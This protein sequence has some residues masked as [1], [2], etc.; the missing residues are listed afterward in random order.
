[1][2]GQAC[3]GPVVFR[4]EA[5]NTAEWFVVDS[6]QDCIPANWLS[7]SDAAGSEIAIGNPILQCCTFAEC[8]TCLFDQVACR[9]AWLTEGLPVSRTWDATMFPIERCGSNQTQL[10]DGE[11]M[12]AH[13]SL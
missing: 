2:D 3:Q 9:N 5:S 1:M 10:R 7:L 6:A 13:R 4:F 11:S 12:C 8:S